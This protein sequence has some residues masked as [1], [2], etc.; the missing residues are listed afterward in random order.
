MRRVP[1]PAILHTIPLHRIT[2]MANLDLPDDQMREIVSAAILQTVTAENRDALITS[3]IASLLAPN[4]S[5]FGSRQSPLQLAFNIAIEQ[6]AKQIVKEMLDTD[7]QIERAV[8]DIII[9]AAKK[10]FS[11]ENKDTM[12]DSMANAIAAGF[13]Q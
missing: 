11:S 10:A 8:E 2:P 12:I 13:R 7:E 1:T 6:K 4:S 5:G 3:A 9:S